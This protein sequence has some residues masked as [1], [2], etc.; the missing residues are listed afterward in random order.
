MTNKEFKEVLSMTGM[1][2]DTDV[3]RRVLNLMS[4]AYQHMSEQAISKY[5]KISNMER[6]QIIYEELEKSGYFNV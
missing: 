5:V 4:I 2:M 3:Y 1:N 6:H